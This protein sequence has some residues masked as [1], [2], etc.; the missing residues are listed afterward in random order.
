MQ[1]GAP[2]YSVYNCIMKDAIGTITLKERDLRD[3]E[4]C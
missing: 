3:S 1:W 2:H 4:T